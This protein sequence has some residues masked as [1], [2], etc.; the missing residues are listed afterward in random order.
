ME[1]PKCFFLWSPPDCIICSM[2][3]ITRTS[4]GLH[5]KTWGLMSIHVLF[6]KCHTKRRME[7]EKEKTFSLSKEKYALDTKLDLYIFICLKIGKIC[8][9]KS[10]VFYFD[11][12]AQRKLIFVYWAGHSGFMG[13]GDLW[14]FIFTWSIYNKSMLGFMGIYQRMDLL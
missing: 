3:V 5:K 9:I 4:W 7:W 10:C 1:K 8:L 11:I 2:S 6:A 13:Y 14:G 12:P